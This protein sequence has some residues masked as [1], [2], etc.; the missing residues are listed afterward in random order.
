MCLS[1]FTVTIEERPY[2]IYQHNCPDCKAYIPPGVVF[3]ALA[4]RPNANEMYMYVMQMILR[5]FY[6]DF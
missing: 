6:K 1:H 2:S 5:I 3:F 4:I